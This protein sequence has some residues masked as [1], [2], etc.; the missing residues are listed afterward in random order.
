MKKSLLNPV[1]YE[2][3]KDGEVFYDIQSRLIKDRVIFLCEEVTHEVAG[4]ISSLLFMMNNED[5]NT[6]ISI[7]LNTPGG[8]VY[9]FL[10]IYDMVQ[11][12]QAPVET[13][14]IGMAMSAGAMLLAAGS[15]GQRLATPNSSIMIHQMQIDGIRGTG[16]EIKIIASEIDKKNKVVLGVLARHTGKSLEEIVKDCEHDKY[17][18]AKEALDYGII[19]KIIPAKKL[20]LLNTSEKSVKKSS[21]KKTASKKTVKK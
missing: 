17:L 6:K 14:C 15:K 16:S 7:W 10:A 2:R 4:V 19:D 5:P 13:V 1:F 21:T 8:D 11:M 3:T 20:D 18:S 9:A 12:I